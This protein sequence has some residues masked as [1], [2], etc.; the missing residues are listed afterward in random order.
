M[1]EPNPFWS[2]SLKIYGV[3]AVARACLALQDSWGADVNLLLYCCWLGHAGRTLDKRSLQMAIARVSRLQTEV[4]KPL[5]QARRALKKSPDGLPAAS[6][7]ELRKRLGALELDLEYLEQRLLADMAQTLAPKMHPQPPRVATAASL[8]R[9]L[10]LLGVPAGQVDGQ[11]EP[12]LKF[13]C[14]LKVK[15][16]SRFRQ[17]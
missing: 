9:Y 13:G 17:D 8:V 3:D 15:A 5:R 14:R 4:V 12:I 1:R 2:Y 10:A 6:V 16:P 11:I 7:A